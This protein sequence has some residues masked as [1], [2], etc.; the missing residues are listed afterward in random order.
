METLVKSFGV[1]GHTADNLNHLPL[2]NMAAISHD[3]LDA[4]SCMKSLVFWS[5]IAVYFLRAH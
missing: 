1:V 4:F 3:I 5:K 2:D